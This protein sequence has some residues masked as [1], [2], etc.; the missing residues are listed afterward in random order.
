M[1]VKFVSVS[2]TEAYPWLFVTALAALRDPVPCAIAKFTV[3]SP[4]GTPRL[5]TRDVSGTLTDAPEAIQSKGGVTP[6]SCDVEVADN[7]AP[8][9]WAGL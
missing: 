4:C 9:D 6:M 7:V 8:T 2:V 1:L 5:T 3:T